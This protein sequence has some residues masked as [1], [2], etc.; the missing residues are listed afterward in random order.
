MWVMS[1]QVHSQRRN[2]RDVVQYL[3]NCDKMTPSLSYQAPQSDRQPHIPSFILLSGKFLSLSSLCFPTLLL[4]L[5]LFLACFPFTFTL[6][7]N[8][9][10]SC[11]VFIYLKL[12]TLISA[13]RGSTLLKRSSCP[14]SVFS[15]LIMWSTQGNNICCRVSLPF[16]KLSSSAQTEHW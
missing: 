3:L 8:K 4:L 7:Q 14:S 5:S 11:T 15:C 2:I 9:K 6:G 12:F 10:T 13:C 16:N 1:D